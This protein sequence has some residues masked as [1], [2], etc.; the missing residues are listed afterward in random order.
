MTKSILTRE[1]D[2]E[3]L[4][5]NREVG[6][7][8]DLSRVVSKQACAERGR[9]RGAHQPPQ[10]LGEAAVLRH[11]QEVMRAL[12][13]ERVEGKC[14]QGSH[15]EVIAVSLSVDRYTRVHAV[16]RLELQGWRRR[17]RRGEIRSAT[18]RDCLRAVSLDEALLTQKGDGAAQLK[19]L[20]E[21]LPIH[22]HTR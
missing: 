14:H 17:D 13:V 9:Q 1:S 21:A 7:E 3:S 10:G 11:Q 8:A 5:G 2:V 22:R 16:I 15:I 6:E 20:T 19:A 18:Q 4:V 12:Q